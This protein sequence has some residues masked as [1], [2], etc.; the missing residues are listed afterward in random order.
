MEE[1]LEEE[2]QEE[3]EDPASEVAEEE[4][5][6][7]VEEEASPSQSICNKLKWFLIKMVF[8]VG[9]SLNFD[10]FLHDDHF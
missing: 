7:T 5:D 3:Q 8:K 9:S 1:E 10:G 4:G 6:V 2:E